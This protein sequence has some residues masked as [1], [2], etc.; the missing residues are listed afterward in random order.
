MEELVGVEILVD[1][2]ILVGVEELVI[3][4]LVVEELVVEELDIVEETGD[5]VVSSSILF[6]HAQAIVSRI[7]VMSITI[8][9]VSSLF[10][11]DTHYMIFK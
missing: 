6:W 8:K 4:E 1:V 10:I 2:E 5:S 7:K 11:D 3:E 9:E